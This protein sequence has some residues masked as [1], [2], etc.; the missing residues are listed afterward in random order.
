MSRPVA[1]GARA[2]EAR[3]R[4]ARRLALGLASL[5]AGVGAGCT[6]TTEGAV[7]YPVMV[8]ASADA[9]GLR[10]DARGEIA[11]ASCARALGGRIT[12]ERILWC[13]RVEVPR[14][15]TMPLVELACTEWRADSPEQHARK[16]LVSAARVAE[17][18]L[19]PGASPP[20][21]SGACHLACFGTAEDPKGPW[22]ARC[23]LG[24]T[25]DADRFLMVRLRTT[26][27]STWPSIEWNPF[28][29]TRQ[30]RRPRGARVGSAACEVVC[31]A[32]GRPPAPGRRFAAA[33]ALERASVVA[34][35]ELAADL[36]NAGA[37]T[38]LV[39]QARRAE[40]DERRHAR[41]MSALAR[42]HGQRALRVPARARRTSARPSLLELA[43]HNAVEGW[44]GEAFGALLA[45]HQAEASVDP[46]VSRALAPI[47]RDEIRHAALALRVHAWLAP[48]LTADER[49]RVLQA[50]RAEIAALRA[51]CPA[52]ESPEAIALGFPAPFTARALV[53]GLD[54]TLWR[55]LGA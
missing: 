46:T 23:T 53:D 13:G 39:D 8:P 17:L 7:D 19:T 35:R 33:A 11:P 50:A 2:L 43:L 14:P 51:A 42:R 32:P 24:Q 15:E 20:N 34:F 4:Q 47:A 44:V 37:P 48:R 28:V 18:G 31:A 38:A 12:P 16:V 29:T 52:V 36:A 45:L 26:S 40:R 5:G 54:A 10:A 30:G 55:D 27:S 1:L 41:A 22:R 21:A 9:R 3:L 6:H 25:L 49:A